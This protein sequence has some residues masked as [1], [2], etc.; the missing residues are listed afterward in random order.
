MDNRRMPTIGD[1]ARLAGVSTGTVSRVL[2]QRA[3]VHPQTRQ[4]VLEV[5]ERLGYVP[6][7]A[8]RELTGRGDTVGILLAPGVR[9]YIPYFV[10]LFEH[11][12][13][14]LWR[15]GMRLEETPTDAAGLPLTPARGY[16]LLGAHD[17][18]PR[19]EALQNTQTPHVL[20]GVYPGAYW[21]APDDEGGAYAATRHLLELG[22]REIAHL[23]GQPQHQVGR[24][25]LLGYRRALEAYNV[26][27]Q[28]HLVLDGD[29]STL[30]AYR[31]LRKA[32]EQGLRFT[33]LFA[34]SDEMAVGALA[35]LEDV[36]LR[37]PQDVSLVGF[38]D[39]PEI[40]TSLTTV[41]QDIGQI[42]GAAVRLLKESLAGGTPHG[43]RVPVQLVVRGTT[44]L[45]E[46]KTA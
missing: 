31:V 29:F 13:E 3:G 34:A 14:A 18:D 46:V 44:S 41:R 43:L 21:V 37:I 42:A 4:R 40:G 28:P 9:R 5:M 36:G 23:T 39:L 45:R 22:H 33:G 15:E 35:A 10:L 6:M 26:P 12:T 8:A 2:N 25:R 7:Q 17:H 20:I 11:L 24:E 27:F 19:L 38:D 32:W 30:T 16:I 1:V